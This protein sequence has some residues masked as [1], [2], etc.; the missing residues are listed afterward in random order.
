[1]EKVEFNSDIISKDES[2]LKLLSPGIEI[3]A[4]SEQME[5]ADNSSAG[6][7]ESCEGDDMFNMM[8]SY[9]GWNARIMP[10]KSE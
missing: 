9:V 7:R 8:A 5:C 1:M 10:S 4:A 6:P 3:H 2:K